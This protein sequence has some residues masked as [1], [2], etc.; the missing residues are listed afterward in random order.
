M[1]LHRQKFTYEV[2]NVT[3][4]WE[5]RS[6][7]RIP[8]NCSVQITLQD[9]SELLGLAHDL[10]VD[11]I[12]FDCPVPLA[13]AE[14][15]EIKLLPPEGSFVTPLTAAIQVIRCDPTDLPHRF[16]IAAALRATK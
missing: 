8:V 9:G 15:A 1:A 12:L 4:G 6:G 11:G 16:M 2:T 3:L 5:K 13:A 7:R 10:S 14:E